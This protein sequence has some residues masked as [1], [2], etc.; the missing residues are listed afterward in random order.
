MMLGI[1]YLIG[2]RT[3]IRYNF[4]P[5][6]GIWELLMLTNSFQV[7]IK[8]I[9][10]KSVFI[11]VLILLIITI[12]CSNYNNNQDLPSPSTNEYRLSNKIPIIHHFEREADH[13]RLY[14]FFIGGMSHEEI[15]QKG[16]EEFT[17]QYATKAAYKY[18]ASV[19][20]KSLSSL[21]ADI[22]CATEMDLSYCRLK[23][24][25]SNFIKAFIIFR[26]I[27][28][29]PT[30]PSN[31]LAVLKTDMFNNIRASSKS[32]SHKLTSK[33]NKA[34]LQG[35][36]YYSTSLLKYRNISKINRHQVKQ[37][38]KRLI[39]ARRIIISYQGNIPYF[40]IYRIMDSSFKHL[41]RRWFS[42]LKLPRLPTKPPSQPFIEI[43]DQD[44][45][46][47]TI[48]AQFKAPSVNTPDF[49]SLL[50][51][52]SIFKERWYNHLTNINIQKYQPT[53]SLSY[54]RYNFGSFQMNHD[55]P[56]KGLLLIK[57][58]FHQISSTLATKEQFNR[59]VTL[60][61]KEF[62][63][64]INS[65]NMAYFLSKWQIL[66]GNWRSMLKYRNRLKR[67]TPKTVR[68]A[69]HKYFTNYMFAISTTD[70]DRIS[71]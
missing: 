58:I 1:N 28:L 48:F 33:L 47:S 61:K 54:N 55:Q 22:K 46:S 15:P 63:N 24:P 13:T 39:N 49:W 34:L 7:I 52:T 35:H 70:E 66:T 27:L 8:N 50:V 3:F 57:D 45:S 71:L 59:A 19:L 18:P 26:Q 56:K 37:H 67:V 41:P 17:L 16:L 6:N 36:P 42:L 32:T 65:N 25:S 68:T 5:G 62:L 14:F 12:S 40:R 31:M 60:A 2:F 11:F 9:S 20:T 10:I 51:A 53:I 43:T 69:A 21:G 23:C 38:Y 4:G 44:N 29:Y 64:N 30:F